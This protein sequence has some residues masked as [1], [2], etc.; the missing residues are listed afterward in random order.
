M[1]NIAQ[2]Y[3]PY[4]DV[5]TS[6]KDRSAASFDEVRGL[7]TAGVINGNI[8]VMVGDAPPTPYRDTMSLQSFRAGVVQPRTVL[9]EGWN[10]LDL[11]R[12]RTVAASENPMEAFLSRP[13]V[14][15]SL[16]QSEQFLAQL[17]RQAY[18]HELRISPLAAVE[19]RGDVANQDGSV[20][21]GKVVGEHPGRPRKPENVSLEDLLFDRMYRDGRFARES[22]ALAW[23]D[24][25]CAEH[26]IPEPDKSVKQGIY[27]RALRRLDNLD[28]ITG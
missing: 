22:E 24:A 27:S 10:G 12:P 18:G 1:N 13:D 26:G 5:V 25:K 11:D 7:T 28:K 3:L 23:I 17:Y 9:D 14:T 16:S 15:I 21:R 4:R 8:L 2:D 19:K 20:M 6:L